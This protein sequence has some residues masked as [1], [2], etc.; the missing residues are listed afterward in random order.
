MGV[1]QGF[2]GLN[3]PHHWGS[4]LHRHI[5]EDPTGTRGDMAN[6]GRRAWAHGF[7]RMSNVCCISGIQNF[8]HR[9]AYSPPSPSLIQPPRTTLTGLLEYGRDMLPPGPNEASPSNWI[10]RNAEIA[11]LRD[12]G[13]LHMEQQSDNIIEA[14]LVNEPRELRNIDNLI[15][16]RFRL[17]PPPLADPFNPILQG[18][19]GVDR[20][21]DSSTSADNYSPTTPLVISFSSSKDDEAQITADSEV[22]EGEILPSQSIVLALPASLAIFS[23]KTRRGG[24]VSRASSVD[25]SLR[26]PANAAQTRFFKRKK[27]MRNGMLRVVLTLLLV[28]ELADMLLRL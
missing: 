7:L 3:E 21:D 13:Y 1:N 16:D 8:Q 14:N 2:F 12:F 15:S 26:L 10:E 28:K 23:A 18:D 4:A 6:L 19:I 5:S 24:Q 20:A 11:H 22:R 17:S 27:D 25:S 9:T